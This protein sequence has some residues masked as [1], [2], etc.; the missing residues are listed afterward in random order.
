MNRRTLDKII[1][2]AGVLLWCGLWIG[3]SVIFWLSI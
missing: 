1:E 2:A 3:A